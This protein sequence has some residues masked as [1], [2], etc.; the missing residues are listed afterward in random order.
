MNRTLKRPM[1]RI[2]GS[3][4]TGITSGL[5]QPRKQYAQ[6]T[7]NPY[8]PSVNFGGVP[9]F[10]TGLGLNLLST[11][12]Q[13][14]LLATAATAAQGPFKNLQESQAAR[15][16]LESEKE[17]LRS[18]R[19]EGQEFE[20]G[21][22]DKRLEVEKMKIN[23]G[24]SL[25]VNQLAAQ[26]LDD[27]DGD[28]N[29]ATNKAKFFLEVRPQLAGTVG[30]TQIGGIIESDLSNEKQA[31]AFAQRN[32]NKVGKV[33]WDINTGKIV[34]LVKDPETNKL[35]FV[36]F[37]ITGDMTPDTEGEILSEANENEVKPKQSIKEVFQPGLTDTDKFIL[38]TIEEGRDKRE[39]GME[40][41]PNY[42]IYR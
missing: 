29:K 16:K 3:A 27:Y 31:K 11:P 40:E 7:P 39:K 36:D 28:L 34:K 35:G 26:Y 13:G 9:G 17:F 37:N 12:P 18:E 38:E 41:I 23:S 20:E 19:L 33:F 2:G 42:N 25:T 30:D 4:G 24:D 5:D 15:R 8:A 10:L 22:L 14:G 6:G 32:R 21:L 1:F